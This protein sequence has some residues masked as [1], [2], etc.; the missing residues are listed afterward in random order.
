MGSNS[1]S[2]LTVGKL[3]AR[4]TALVTAKLTGRSTRD[5]LDRLDALPR[6]RAALETA[7]VMGG[8][9]A[10]ALLAASVG[11]IGLLVYFAVILL[12]FR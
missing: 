2:N 8:L 1:S 10:S 7:V 11:V 6:G 3:L 12:V 4:V 5:A 9:F